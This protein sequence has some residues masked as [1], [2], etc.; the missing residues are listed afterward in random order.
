MASRYAGIFASIA[1]VV[2]M[3]LALTGA[4]LYYMTAMPG[5]SYQGSLLPLNVQERQLAARLRTHVTA[6]ASAEHNVAHYQK[7]EQAA[8][9]IETVLRGY[10]CLVRRQEF[11]SDAGSVRN[12]EITVPCSSPMA[13]K[14][15]LVV[16]GAHYDSA[17]GAPGANDNASGVAALIE[18]ARLLEDLKS[19]GDREVRLVFF[20]NEEIP[21]FKTSQMGSWVHASELNAQGRDVVAM[22]SLETLGYYSDTKGSQ[23]YPFPFALIYPDKGN[24]LGFVGT[25]GSRSLVRRAIASFRE[26]ASFPSEGVAAPGFIAGVDWSDHWSYTEHGHPGLMITDTALYRYPYYHTADDSP[27]K[28]DYDRLARIVKGVESVIRELATKS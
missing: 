14:R 10:G 27:D 11:D 6:I 4:A 20:V 2:I 15:R 25:L 5:H 21:Y 13:Q 28:I 7:L 22:V 16:V 3:P 17:T 23:R 8:T 26:H 12:L 9:H 24:F 1:A 18:L 19:A